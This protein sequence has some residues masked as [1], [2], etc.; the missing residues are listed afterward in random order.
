MNNFYKLLTHI[1][2]I[3]LFTKYAK[4]ELIIMLLKFRQIYVSIFLK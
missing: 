2:Y 3:S 1:E 4:K